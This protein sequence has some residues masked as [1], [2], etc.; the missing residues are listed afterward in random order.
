MPKAN[1]I[2]MAALILPWIPIIIEI[3]FDRD[4]Y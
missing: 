1:A 3:L 4:D 2:L